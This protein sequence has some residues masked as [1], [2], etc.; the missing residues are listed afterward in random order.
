MGV[1]LFSWGYWGWGNATRQ[2]VQAVDAAEAAKD[3][4]PP[5]FVDIRFHRT[6]KAKG[7]IGRNFE[8]TVG[9]SRY[10]YIHGLGN[11]SIE[12]GAPRIVIDDPKKVEDLL[13]LAFHLAHHDQRLIFYCACE[14][15]RW[16]HRYRVATLALKRAERWGRSVR[17]VEWPGAKPETMQLD[18]T[19]ELLAALGNGRK[20][21]PIGKRADWREFAGLPWGSTL[22]LRAGNE[23]LWVA[24][25]PARFSDGWFLPV[26]PEIEPSGDTSR[27]KRAAERFRR[28][29]GFESRAP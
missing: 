10:Q 20:S 27:V 19:A 14:Y 5:F 4:R 23:S 13:D 2:L 9:A 22:R 1:T 11:R 26:I 15:P 29:Y 25:G 6:G 16:C 7:F 24:S 3:F 8:R 12:T 17:I 18:V 21:I 28:R